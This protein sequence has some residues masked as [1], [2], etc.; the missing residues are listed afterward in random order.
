MSAPAVI[1]ASASSGRVIPQILINTV[2]IP[3]PIPIPEPSPKQLPHRFFRVLRPHQ[4]L[5]Y[6][7]SVVPGCAQ[8]VE[9]CRATNPALCNPHTV[10]RQLGSNRFDPIEPYFKGREVACVDAEDRRP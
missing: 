10:G 6:Q 5:T 3:F 8:P 9:V 7:K 4:M 2:P 1:A